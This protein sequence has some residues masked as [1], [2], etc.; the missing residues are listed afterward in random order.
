LESSLFFNNI[1]SSLTNSNATIMLAL[2]SSFLL[3]RQIE[4]HLESQ[5]KVQLLRGLILMGVGFAV[6]MPISSPADRNK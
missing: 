2:F 4:K 5:R 1:V 3:N 6:S